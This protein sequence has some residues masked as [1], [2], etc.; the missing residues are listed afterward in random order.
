MKRKKNEVVTLVFGN[1]DYSPLHL[2]NAVRQYN[3]K[4]T[5]TEDGIRTEFELNNLVDES[6]QIKFNIIRTKSNKIDHYEIIGTTYDLFFIGTIITKIVSEF[7][8]YSKSEKDSWK[9]LNEYVEKSKLNSLI[10]LEN[11]SLFSMNCRK[12]KPCF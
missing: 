1:N 8:V 3:H 4:F 2:I 6:N 10:E 12:Y 9:S 11:D 5:K 7:V